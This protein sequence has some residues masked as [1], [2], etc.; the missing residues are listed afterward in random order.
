MESDEYDSRSN[1]RRNSLS[2]S[3]L[4]NDD[5]I[6]PILPS[7][8]P[9][10]PEEKREN[11]KTWPGFVTE[12]V[13][14]PKRKR[15]STQQF[16]R[17]MAV[18]QQTDTPSSEVR[19][20]LAEELDMT[21][22]E[23]QVWFQNRRAKASRARATAIALA[24]SNQSAISSLSQYY[25]HQ[26]PPIWADSNN[27]GYATTRGSS[28]YSSQTPP[29][30]ASISQSDPSSQ[31]LLNRH[32]PPPTPLSLQPIAPMPPYNSATT[33]TNSNNNN[34]NISNNNNTSIGS[35]H[36]PVPPPTPPFVKPIIPRHH[37]LQ[38]GFQNLSLQGSVP[39][40]HVKK[41]P[42][43]AIE[44]YNSFDFTRPPP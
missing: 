5:S 32:P 28:I 27:L 19:E 22:R 8:R 2:I 1:S 40:H 16:N 7:S 24:N 26:P 34:N 11:R 39:D 35:P 42:K 3:A 43:S 18:Y 10:T 23:V 13:P 17:L 37:N 6:D 44:F 33:N 12:E 36:V 21:K 25:H 41:R 20:Q 4:L 9:L 38:Q 14:K 30:R 31:L 29:R 15:T